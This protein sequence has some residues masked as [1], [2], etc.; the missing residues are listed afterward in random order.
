MKENA[1]IRFIGKNNPNFGKI[2]H[3]KGKT[4]I[5]EYGEE[6]ALKISKK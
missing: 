1:K 3:R 6:K 5:E 4:L 2:S